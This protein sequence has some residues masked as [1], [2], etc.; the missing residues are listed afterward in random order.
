MYIRNVT[1]ELPWNEN[2]RKWRTRSQSRIKNIVVHQSLGTRTVKST[3]NYCITNSEDIA[4]GRSMPHIPYHYFIEPNS[5]VFK[6]NWRSH[7][8][9]HVKG[10][11]YVSLGVCLGGFY[12][13]ADQTCRDGDPSQIQLDTLEEL[14]D[15]LT[16]LVKLPKTA[17]YTHDF[18][19]GKLYA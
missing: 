7:V 9:W 13:Y 4:Y 15:F 2:G 1:N 3:N 14:L 18:L 17:V 12:N 16:R 8:T 11:N 5:N 19:Q 6:C 10:L